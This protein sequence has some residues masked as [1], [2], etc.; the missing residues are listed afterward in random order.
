MRKEIAYK[1]ADA[2]RSGIYK[3]EKKYLSSYWG[4]CVLG[5]LCDLYRIKKHLKIHWLVSKTG[6][7]YVFLGHSKSL[8]PQVMKW[9][10]IKDCF[11]E[12]NYKG[13]KTS[14]SKLNDEGFTFPQL[15]DI[16]EKNYEE[17]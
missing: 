12:L 16:I 9:A 10:D 17:I 1:W 2:L 4:F 14:L 5:V 3:Q 8:P 6:Y 11:A 13:E 15:A 7:S